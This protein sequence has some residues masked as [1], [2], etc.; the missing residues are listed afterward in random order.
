MYEKCDKCR[1]PRSIYNEKA[2]KYL[3]GLC[4]DT[5][6]V[7][8]KDSKHVSSKYLLFKKMAMDYKLILTNAMESKQRHAQ[9]LN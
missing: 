7:E 2:N 4:G 3:C 8:Y 5:D 9:M 1:N 6:N